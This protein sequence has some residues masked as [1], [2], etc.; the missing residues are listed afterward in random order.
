MST[1]ASSS[2][3]NDEHE[4]HVKLSD[5]MDVE[6]VGGQE[7]HKQPLPLSSSSSASSPA[8]SLSDGRPNNF[9][10]LRVAVVGNVDSGKCWA[11]GTQLRMFDG[12]LKA[13]ETFVGGEQLMGS[14]GRPRTV[15]AGSIRAGRAEMYCIQPTSDGFQSFTVNGDHILV[16][17]V[18]E[19]PFIT[20]AADGAYTHRVN[21]YERDTD[22]TV[23]A[24]SKHCRNQR[25]ASD[26]CIEKTAK[27]DG[28]YTYEI[29]VNDY[30]ASSQLVKAASKLFTCRAVTFQPR[31][32]GLH[33]Q[34]A[35]V[36]GALPS[37]A[38]IEWAAW[39]LGVWV[40]DG[41]AAHA[42]VC[43]GAA[44]DLDRHSH[45][46]IMTRL[47]QYHALFGE[48]VRQDGQ[49]VSSASH[50]VFMFR[51]GGGA[52]V[53]YTHSIAHRL[54]QSYGLINNKHIPQAWICDTLEVRRRIF[55]GVLDGDGYY[56]AA[57]NIY[58]VATK[59][60]RVATGLKT[61]AGSLGIRKGEVSDTRSI[62]PET[63]EVY[64][65]F[66]VFFSGDMWEIV[67]YAALTCKQ[68]PRPGAKNFVARNRDN[69]CT[70]MTVKPVGVG[71][72]H[73]FTVHGGANERILLEDFLVTHNSTIIGVLTGGSMD[74][75]RGLA[76]SRVF[77]HKHESATGRT[78][79]I[80]Q[81]IMGYDVQHSPV[82]NSST[83]SSSAAVK[84]KGWSAVVQ[85]SA[86]IVTFIDLAGHE[87]YL[88]TTIAGLTGCFPDYA[89][90]V[91]NSL[92]GITKMTR[93][94]LG[95]VLALNIP[96]I[97]AVTKVDLASD[98]IL[99]QTKRELFKVLKSGA[100]NKLPVQMRSA[101]DVE[102]VIGAEGDK[103]CPVFFVSCVTGV[104][105]NLLHDYIGRLKTKR[106]DWLKVA[107]G[108]S[109]KSA[110]DVLEHKDGATATGSDES[111]EAG[112][113]EF[114]IDETFLVTGVGVVVSGTV[115]RGRMNGPST[116]LL[117]PNSD[118]SFRPV[119]VRTLHCK[120]MAVDTVGAGDSCAASLRALG[121]KDHITRSSIRRGMLLIDPAL[122][123]T[124]TTTFDAEVHILHH[125]TTIKLG[126]QAV[127]H[128]G[129]VRQ[130]ATI[131]R[132]SHLNANTTPAV[133]PSQPTSAS[134]SAVTP[135]S[136]SSPSIT[137]AVSNPPST[138][139]ALRTGDKALVR[140]RFLLRPE[141]LHV[142]TSFLFRE[143][144]TKGIGH[145]VR[146]KWSKEE[147]K[148][149]AETEEK[150][151][152]ERKPLGRQD[153]SEVSGPDDVEKAAPVVK[154]LGDDPGIG[155]SINGLTGGLGSLLISS[156]P[157]VHERKD[158][159]ENER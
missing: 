12:S 24:Q 64:D 101:K 60:L 117:G 126:Y 100:A 21:W 43:Q 71:D 157:V 62:D 104:H 16:L 46:P 31:L 91:I 139:S 20:V 75:G 123:P 159:K 112:G 146:A 74:N 103:I 78:S 44:S 42:S 5:H 110:G 106:V 122:N 107:S 34:L 97:V 79:C 36:L 89:L 77:M 149:M 57:S 148:S 55:A 119:Y 98:H 47:L 102:M 23:R 87:K 33:L 56:A 114:L 69:R 10:D 6:A 90:I 124:A 41:I 109:D 7:E 40:T 48:Q 9:Y 27:W 133:A 18:T 61:L 54:L 151:R 85:S 88:K 65:G 51:F 128:A 72:Y 1:A 105:I 58:E 4:P 73:G 136:T 26:E 144:S 67:Q 39:Y 108:S 82:Y 113:C 141:F 53:P 115:Q 45:R 96:L 81:H 142:G 94:H 8:T 37:A 99:G 14:D 68:C 155:A 13:V 125:P 28:P 50:P 25:E 15:T 150:E 152:R 158:K 137:P 76:R 22:G 80:S 147:L 140:F 127:I 132:I 135:S 32:D 120:R 116:L 154:R 70:G 145:V 52:G 38:Q 118:G 63:D 49:N 29:S 95:V 35:A 156:T 59:T 93:E 3:E 134:S 84:T 17:T 111:G 153:D 121:R 130:A 92:A 129:M 138:S 30:L 86:H 19:P 2:Y 66:R 83:A 131:V 11:P 143:G